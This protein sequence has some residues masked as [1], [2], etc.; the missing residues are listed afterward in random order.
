MKSN[1]P[2][3]NPDAG[4]KTRIRAHYEPRISPHRPN[5]DILDWASPQSQRARFRVLA[6]NA[7]LQ[8]RKL[9]DVGCGLGDLRAYLLE[10]HIAADYTGVDISEKMVQAARQRH[11]DGAFICADL[12]EESP[13]PPKSFDVVYCSGI[14]NL[15][16]G[17]NLE[18]LPRAMRRLFDLSGR[19]VVFNL[20]H[21]RAQGGDQKYFYHSPKE[22]LEILAPLGW[23]MNLLD[24]YLPNDFTIVCQRPQDRMP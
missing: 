19:D 21:R 15:N 17:N 4:H 10:H 23:R 6:D 22:V 16:L 20:L 12:F 2:Q 11:P 13:F 8:G 14:F 18:F 3:D 7:T 5:Y 24:D 9:L 1:R